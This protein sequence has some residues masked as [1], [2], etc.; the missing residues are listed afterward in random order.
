M[1]CKLAFR[2]TKVRGGG[3]GHVPYVWKTDTLL[4]RLMQATFVNVLVQLTLIYDIYSNHKVRTLAGQT[5]LFCCSSLSNR[6]PIRL[7]FVIGQL[8]GDQSKGFGNVD[9]ETTKTFHV[10]H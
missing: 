5:F 3:V 9:E 4:V 2:N 10:G 8:A 1:H 6:Q 7:A